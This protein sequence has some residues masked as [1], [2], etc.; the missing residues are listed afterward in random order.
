MSRISLSTSISVSVGSSKIVKCA[1][2]VLTGATAISWL[3]KRETTSIPK[4]IATTV[5]TIGA[6]TYCIGGIADT[7]I[8]G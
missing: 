1:C 7:L 2:I 3:S 8:D 4:K 6:Y 5:A